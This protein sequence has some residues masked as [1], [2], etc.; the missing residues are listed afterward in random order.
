MEVP[1]SWGLGQSN[2]TGAEVALKL[3]DGATRVPL[4]VLPREGFGD[5]IRSIRI[6]LVGGEGENLAAQTSG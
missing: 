6:Q 5:A 2:L 1:L 3:V 4:V